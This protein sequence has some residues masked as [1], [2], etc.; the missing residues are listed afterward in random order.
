MLVRALAVD[1][2][3][4]P[5]PRASGVLRQARCAFE[6]RFAEKTRAKIRTQTRRLNGTGQLLFFFFA[7]FGGFLFNGRVR[8]KNRKIKIKRRSGVGRGHQGPVVF[9]KQYHLRNFTL[10]W[11]VP[12]KLEFFF[13]RLKEKSCFER[14]FKCF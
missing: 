14:H 11:Y 2:L 7:L 5:V 9:S 10:L 8:P 12:N 1:D 4:Q 6:E 13:A 3:L